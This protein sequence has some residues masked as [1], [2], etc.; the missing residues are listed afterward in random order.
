M[1]AG[2]RREE[3]Q[4]KFLHSWEAL[5][6]LDTAGSCERTEHCYSLE[7]PRNLLLKAVEGWECHTGPMAS[8]ASAEL[9][10]VLLNSQLLSPVPHWLPDRARPEAHG[11]SRLC[12]SCSGPWLRSVRNLC[13]NK[14]LTKQELCH[15][16]M[17]WV[18]LAM[19]WKDESNL[20]TQRDMAGRFVTWT[21]NTA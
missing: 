13:S 20:N 4:R 7:T 12:Q 18:S 9:L 5:S 1:R 11:R 15:T 3:R 17:L 14:L 10:P 21:G 19:A 2:D 6:N 8:C 16:R